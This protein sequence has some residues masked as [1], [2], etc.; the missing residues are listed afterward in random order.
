[1]VS[2]G[3]LAAAIEQPA[4]ARAVGSAVA[5]NDLAFLIPCH[6]VIRETGVLGGYRWG[7]ARKR[8]MLGWEDLRYS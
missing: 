3:R 6:R 4:A 7:S 1:L 2:Y 5:A 8:L